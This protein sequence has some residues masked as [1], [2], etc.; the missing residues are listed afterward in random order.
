MADQTGA[1]TAIKEPIGITIDGQ[2]IKDDDSR[3]K[4]HEIAKKYLEDS[5]LTIEGYIVNWNKTY[6][7]LR[8]E[9]EAEVLG[10]LFVHKSKIT[11]S[12]CRINVGQRMK[13]KLAKDEKYPSYMAV[14]V[15][16]LPPENQCGS[17]IF[18]SC[19][20]LPQSLAPTSNPR[21][22]PLHTPSDSPHF[23]SANPI[24]L[25]GLKSSCLA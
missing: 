10:N 2:K 4:E 20:A 8:P 19:L 1:E 7:F 22:S 3:P 5:S 16:L 24:V 15:K 12:K 14:E 21:H 17:Y 9:G 23:T 13:V 6:G 25:V 11:S 18:E